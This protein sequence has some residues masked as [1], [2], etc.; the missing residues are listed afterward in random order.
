MLSAVPYDRKRVLSALTLVLLLPL[1][2]I[3]AYLNDRAQQL[4]ATAPDEVEYKGTLGSVYSAPATNSTNSSSGNSNSNDDD[5]DDEESDAPSNGNT[6]G[7][8]DVVVR[9]G[10]TKG[11]SAKV[12]TMYVYVHNT[13][14]V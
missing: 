8:A 3:E 14:H 9:P 11:L 13:C 1:Q 5:D 6:N 10:A 4:L 12:S 2:Q 7:N